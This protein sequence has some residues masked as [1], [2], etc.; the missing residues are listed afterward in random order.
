MAFPEWFVG[1]SAKGSSTYAVYE[2]TTAA[3]ASAYTA[4]GYKGPVPTAAEAKALASEITQAQAAVASVQS[5]P[6]L[7]GLAAI[8][9]FFNTLN[10]VSGKA[11]L[12]R[13]TKIV[14]GGLLLIIGLVHIT[15]AGGAVADAARKVPV[16]I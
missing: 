8:G 16:P 11:L 2:A 12:I 14:V 4:D 1:P 6:N 7:S 13:G 9:A 3:Q 10:H 15:G 5:G